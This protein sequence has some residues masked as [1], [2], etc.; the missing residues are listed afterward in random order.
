MGLVACVGQ[1]VYY[2]ED[3]ITWTQINYDTGA[4][5][6]LEVNL[7][8]LTELNRP[9]QDQAQFAIIKGATGYATN[10][11]GTL[12][13]ATGA[14]NVAVFHITGIGGS[15]TFITKKLQLL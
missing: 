8:G 11:Y 5:G 14:D 15:R 4:A 7:S 3:G 12:A 2:T 9:S 10:P 6:S 1:S 13:I